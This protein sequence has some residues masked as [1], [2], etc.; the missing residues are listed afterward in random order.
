M[1]LEIFSNADFYQIFHH[2]FANGVVEMF[3][4][5]FYVILMCAINIRSIHFL[6]KSLHLKNT[7]VNYNK[8]V[9]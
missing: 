6:H 5:L 9:L 7:V 4:L 3:N 8:D 2:R 1:F